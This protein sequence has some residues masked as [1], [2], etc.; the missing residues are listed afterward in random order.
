MKSP[1]NTY[2]YVYGKLYLNK[3]AACITKKVKPEVCKNRKIN[4]RQ[5]Y[6]HFS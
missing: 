5:P 3:S 1:L 4:V 2:E 6:F